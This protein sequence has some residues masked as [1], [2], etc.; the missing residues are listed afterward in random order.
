V[1]EVLLM[2]TVEIFASKPSRRNFPEYITYSPISLDVMLFNYPQIN[3][4]NKIQLLAYTFFK[5]R[6]SL[7]II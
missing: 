5:V 1:T 6:Y 7:M 3:K 4:Y 2:S